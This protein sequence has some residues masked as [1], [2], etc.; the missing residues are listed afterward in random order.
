MRT[1]IGGISR[2]LRKMEVW[3]LIGV[4]LVAASVVAILYLV[5]YFYLA[6]R[7]ALSI[8]LT[9]PEKLAAFRDSYTKTMAQLFA[10]FAVVGTFAWTIFKDGETLRQTSI[11]SANQQFVD[12]S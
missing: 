4:V 5:T 3:I 8:G 1:L 6:P 9:D 7:A 10:G 2:L 12:A 11:Q